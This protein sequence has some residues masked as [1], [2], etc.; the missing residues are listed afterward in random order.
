M[1]TIA[2]GD[3]GRITQGKSGLAFWRKKQGI[4]LKDGNTWLV[5]ACAAHGMN[6]SP[7]KL[8]IV[9]KGYPR[10]TRTCTQGYEF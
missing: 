10:V 2:V 4:F 3:Y 9:G 8:V 6:G 7:F 1:I 5:W